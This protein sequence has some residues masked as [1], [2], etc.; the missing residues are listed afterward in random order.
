VVV[1]FPNRKPNGEF[2][3]AKKKDKNKNNTHNDGYLYQIHS[4]IALH[5]PATAP[6][7]SLDNPQV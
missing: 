1:V 6:E 3:I 5:S 7:N 2:S 4:S